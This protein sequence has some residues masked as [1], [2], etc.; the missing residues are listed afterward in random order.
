MSADHVGFFCEDPT[1][2]GIVMSILTD[3]WR[4]SMGKMLGKDIVIGVPD[5]PYLERATENGRKFFET[6]LDRLEHAGS[7]V[8]RIQTF[9][10][11]G[12]IEKNHRQLIAAEMSR[13]H[14]PWYEENRH[15]Y[16]PRTLEQI[17]NGLKVSDAEIESLKSEQ[18]RLRERIEQEMRS[19]EIQYWVCPPATDHAPRG[20]QNTGDAVMNLPWTSAGLPVVTLP[21]GKD[22]A[23]LPQGVQLVGH[24]MEDELLVPIA[25]KLFDIFRTE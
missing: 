4:S 8:K 16:R 6:Q 1:G 13:Y 17:E 12:T 5:G 25:E 18:G 24:F 14:A 7:R 22:S 2:I 3:N 23:D 20:L 10:D 21:A 19:E 9:S 11:F 15:L